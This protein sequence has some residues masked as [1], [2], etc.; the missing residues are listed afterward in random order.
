[1]GFRY[2]EGQ[3]L[4][5]HPGRE[6]S[7]QC[8]EC[9]ATPTAAAADIGPRAEILT[10]R[11]RRALHDSEMVF[12]APASAPLSLVQH[13]TDAERRVAAPTPKAW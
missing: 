5:G 11:S 4:S 12:S 8:G 1:M 3:I 2:E 13:L 9:I 7:A 6:A 10:R